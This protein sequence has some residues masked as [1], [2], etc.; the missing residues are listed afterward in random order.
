M[1]VSKRVDNVSS[2]AVNAA[3]QTILLLGANS[4]AVRIMASAQVVAVAGEYV[5]I[6]YLKRKRRRP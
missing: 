3:A 2:V 4:V 1:R 6:Y 5:I